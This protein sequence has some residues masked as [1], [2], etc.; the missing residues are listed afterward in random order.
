MTEL[1]EAFNYIDHELLI[2]KLHECDFDIESL[3]FT[4]NHL[5][6]EKERLK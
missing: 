6:G 5:A 4:N 1:L 2:A 3:K